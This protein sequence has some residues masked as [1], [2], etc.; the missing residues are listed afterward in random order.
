MEET[1]GAAGPASGP[2]TANGDSDT[3]TDEDL[4]SHQFDQIVDE[5]FVA[6]NEQ[7]MKLWGKEEKRFIG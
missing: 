6:T 2:S 4:G 3:D 7:Q 5:A 1:V